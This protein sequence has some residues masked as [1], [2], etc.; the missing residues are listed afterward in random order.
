MKTY[1][2]LSF[3]CVTLF[4]GYSLAKEEDPAVGMPARVWAVFN[5]NGY[6][7][8]NTAE[9]LQV[10][11]DVYVPWS[12]PKRVDWVQ[13]CTP[14]NYGTASTW[15]DTLG[16]DVGR[17]YQFLVASASTSDGYINVDPAPGYETLIGGQARRRANWY[18]PWLYYVQVQPINPGVDRKAAEFLTSATVTLALN[19]KISLGSLRNGRSAGDIQLAS[20]GTA[21]DWSSLYT[22]AMLN[23][24]TDSDE[25]AVYRE[26]D[27]LRQI[28]ANEVVVN[29]ATV[30]S[31][32]YEISF[33]N[34]SQ[35]TPVPSTFPRSFTNDPFLTYRVEKGTT[36]TSL[37]LTKEAR[38]VTGTSG[39]FPVIRREFMT[40]T[41]T[42]TMPN[43]TWS[44]TAWTKEG[45]ATVASTTTQSV[46]GANSTR[47]EDITVTDPITNSTALRLQ[48]IYGTLPSTAEV[49]T[50]ETLGSNPATSQTT[51][52]DYEMDVYSQNPGLLKGVSFPGGGWVAYE[53]YPRDT[54]GVTGVVSYKYRPY[55]NAPTTITR[56]PNVGEVVHYEYAIDEFG[57]QTWPSLVE[58]KVNG[59]STS[60]STFTYA[61]DQGYPNGHSVT[62][63]TRTDYA[64]GAHP[65][66]T[67]L[68]KYRTDWGQSLYRG[69]PY[70][71]KRPDGSQQSYA[72]ERHM[73]WTGVYPRHRPS[74]ENYYD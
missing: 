43:F 39:S 29:I 40:I 13:E 34:P 63:T 49:V 59:I 12:T 20:H 31:T 48:R 22:P 19:W 50:A 68:L 21:D 32:T 14:N 24:E 58:A 70:A 2:T 9:Y 15:V 65:L 47:T 5:T 42:G 53:Y 35:L 1:G 67:V 18:G 30:N 37:K 36:T 52:F 55:N 72:Y 57:T 74:H 44:R 38:D 73:G 41:R 7:Q 45:E 62:R 66:V 8:P 16:L 71:I 17:S 4:A 56:D 6:Y 25:I 51:T 61:F 10:A 54:V 26:N 28:I 46:G 23:Y 64:D 69:Q 27:V 33:Y 11:H 60:K 3:M